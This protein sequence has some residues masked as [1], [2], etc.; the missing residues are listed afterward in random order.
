MFHGRCIGGESGLRGVSE[1]SQRERTGEGT[2][3]VRMLLNLTQFNRLFLDVKGL[4][5]ILR[6]IPTNVLFNR[7]LNLPS[8][9][10]HRQVDTFSDVLWSM[11]RSSTCNYD[12]RGV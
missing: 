6:S 9:F 5:V 1:E 10:C 11:S 3:L 2:F 12:D 8:L 4:K 7:V